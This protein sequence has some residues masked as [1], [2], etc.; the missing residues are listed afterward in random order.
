[1]GGGGGGERAGKGE[2]P[3][4]EPKRNFNKQ[5]SEERSEREVSERSYRALM[6]ARNIC[7]PLLNFLRSAQCDEGDGGLW[8][9]KRNDHPHCLEQDAQWHFCVLLFVEAG[10]EG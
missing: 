6:K 1:M 7:E 5:Q 9:R 10:D 8:N 3:Q 2:Q 4:H